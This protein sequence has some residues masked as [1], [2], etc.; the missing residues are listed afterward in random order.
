M[1]TLRWGLRQARVWLRETPN[2]TYE[3]ETVLTGEQ[4]ATEV[5]LRE[6]RYVAVELLV[7]AGARAHYGGLGATFV[8][9]SAK[10]LAIEV[11]VSSTE[12]PAIPESL[13]NQVD[14]VHVGLPGEYAKA[15]LESMTSA[16][17]AQLLPGG[18]VRVCGALHGVAG[19]SPWFFQVLS[20]VALTLLKVD[21]ERPSE[22]DLIALIE[23]EL[24]ARYTDQ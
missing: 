1:I 23:H 21:I 9:S 18:T 13:A 3:A 4:Q 5:H 22:T 24:K 12:G 7:P 15:I 10:L 20:R 16:H 2:W 17:A 8:P 14:S 19:S 11:P 6:S